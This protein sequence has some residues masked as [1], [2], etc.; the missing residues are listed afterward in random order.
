MDALIRLSVGVSATL[1]EWLRLRSEDLHY[2]GVWTAGAVCALIAALALLR[3]LVRHLSSHRIGRTHVALPAVLPVMRTSG[4]SVVRHGAF[5]VWL[6][7]LPFFVLAL[8]D[9]HTSFRRDEVTYAGRRIAIMIDG[10]SSMILKFKTTT[11]RPQGEPTY[12]MAAAAAERFMRLRMAGPYRDLV[13]LIQF[14]DQA[15]VLTPFTTDYEN[16]LLGIRLMSNPREWGRFPEFGTTIIRGLEQG[17]MLFKVFDFINASGNLLLVFSDGRDSETTFRGRSLDTLMTEARRNRIPIYMLRTAYGMAL[18]QV[19]QDKIW[20]P[21]VERSGGRFY[22]VPDEPSLLQA[23]RDIDRLTAG[24]IDIHEYTSHR[25]QF[26]GYVLVAI[27]LWLTAALLH[28]WVP[29]F[30]TFP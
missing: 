1:S 6:A 13:S 4:W 27:G 26:A 17:L 10:S 7:G 3:L 30:R 24:R 2:L 5:A 25:P 11:L 22:P 12:F 16:V 28:L 18:G 15:Y 20:K 9:P 14:G 8:A 21:A 19:P 23:L 29:W